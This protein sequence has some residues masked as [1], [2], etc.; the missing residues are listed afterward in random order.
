[1]SESTN[2]GRSEV[3]VQRSGRL[4]RIVLN[5]PQALNALTLDMVR[6]I[7]AALSEF[8]EIDEITTVLIEGAGDRGLCAGGDM[9]AVYEAI[10]AHD[11][12]LREFWRH[13]YRLNA[14]IARCSKPVVAF[15]DGIVMGGGVGLSAHAALRVVTERSAIA[16]PE[17]DIGFAPD[18][19]GTWLLSRAPGELGTHV[20][21]TAARLGAVD[22]IA[23]GL[24]D[25]YVPSGALAG[26][27]EALSDLAAEPTI[28]AA[29][30][31]VDA[32]RSS[33]LLA[34]S[35][36]IDACYRVDSAEAIVELLHNDDHEE[37]HA[38]ATAIVAKCPLSVKVTLRALRE[39]RRFPSL[40]ACLELEYRISCAF[41]DTS[42]LL[43]GIRATLI[44]KD[45]AP[46]WRPARLEDVTPDA[47]E[48]FFSAVAR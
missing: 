17:V 39:A 20:A 30:L 43:E 46:R 15:M 26:L 48:R 18:A 13:E 42:D 47:V 4:G 1:M 10:R 7:D 2:S 29:A 16:M 12:A 22:A 36:W 32:L 9:R 11:R 3:I 28:A 44:D 19:G 45:R 41:L 25:V 33:A 21:L 6:A 14:H 24:A 38:A 31:P 8:E 35:G 5:R 34:H 40:E 23:C 37:A 27:V